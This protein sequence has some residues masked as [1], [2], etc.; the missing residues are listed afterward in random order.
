M[1]GDLTKLFE[2]GNI[3]KIC[4]VKTDDGS[5]FTFKLR[6][7]TPIEDVECREKAQ[8]A[9][10]QKFV[11]YYTTYLFCR[12]IET[13][14]DVKLEDMPIATGS[15]VDEKRLSVVSRLGQ[16]FMMPLQKAYAEL[17]NR[18]TIDDEAKEEEVKK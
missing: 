12:A 8:K 15:T 3:T 14:N 6:T 9:G 11:T 2:H 13:I 4:E 17:L 18:I 5:I 7:L 10:E 16:V 1:L